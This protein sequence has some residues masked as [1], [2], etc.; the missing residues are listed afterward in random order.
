VEAVHSLFERQVER[1]PEAIAI[2]I[3]DTQVTYR[4]LNRHANQLAHALLDRGVSRD[5]FVGICLD[6]SVEMVAALLGTL[7]A[8]AAYVPLDPEYPAERL[9]Y[10][11]EDSGVRALF[12]TR[13]E[14]ACLEIDAS[15]DRLLVLD[16]LEAFGD[17]PE[18]DPGLPVDP[19]QLIYMIYTSG[20]TGKPK[21]SL[22]RHRGFANL[23]RWYAEEFGFDAET[24]VLHMTSP[25]FDLTQKNVFAPLAAGSRLCLLDQRF[26]DASVIVDHIE[27]H[28]CTLVNCTPSAFARLFAF[29]GDD[30]YRRI[31][32]LHFVVLGGEPIPMARLKDWLASDAC[33]AQI[34]NSYGPTE[35]TDVVSFY[36]VERPQRFLDGN[37]P[38][39][40]AL[41]GFRL[42]V[43]DDALRPVRT[44]ESGQLCIA[45]VGVGAG[46][47]GRPELTADRFREN[48]L[49]DGTGTRL[50]L[51]GDRARQLEDGNL[52]YLGR[53]DNQVKVRGFRI[54][55]GEVERALEAHEAIKEAAAAVFP[56]PAGDNR[57]AAY[58]VWE[59]EASA[60]AINEVRRFLQRS[61][62]DFMLP[63]AWVAL[64]RL[65]LTPNGKLDR[66]ALPEPTAE[67]P[68]LD[69]EFVEPRNAVEAYLA[70]LWLEVIGIDRIGIDDRF[71]ELG[72][73]SLN[74]VDFVARLSSELGERIPIASFFE[75]PT[76]RAFATELWMEHR[77]AMT[78]RFPD[79]AESARDEAPERGALVLRERGPADG[80]LA[81]VGM[82]GR[83]PG[84]DD[85][86]QL[87]ENLLDGV[88]SVRFASEEDLREAGVVEDD[89]SD[90]EYVRAYFSC[91]DVE[92][93]D[94]GFF[95]YTPREAELMDP[96]HRFFL[97]VAWSCLDNAGYGEPTAY[98]GR[99][100]VFGGA[101][102]DAYLHH[103][104]SLHPRYRDSLGDFSVN[105]GNDKNFPST[106]VAYKL[107][108]RGP[109]IN[110]QTAC[111]SSGVALHLACQSLRAGECDMALVGG[112]RVLVPTRSGYRHVENGP[113]S[114][115]GH[116]RTFDER[117][118]GMVR[119]SGAAFLLVKRLEDALNDQDC[120][121]GIVKAT[122]VNN[123]GSAKVGFTAPGVEGQAEVIA[124]AVVRAGVPVESIGYVEA[125]GTATAL[126]DPIEVRALTRAY[127]HFTDARQFC[128]IGSVKTNLGHLDAGAA[129][130]GIIKT[131][132]ALETGELPP[133]LH[134]ASPNPEI[135]FANSPFR[136]TERRRHW[137]A[138]Q[139]PRRAGVSSFGL[140]GTNFHGVFEEFRGPTGGSSHEGHRRWQLV[141]LSAKTPRSLSANLGGLARY[142]EVHPEVEVSDL[143]YSLNTFRP[144]FGERA[145]LLCEAGEEIGRTQLAAARRRGPVPQRSLVFFFPDANPDAVASREL[146]HDEAPFRRAI[147][148]CSEA[149]EPLLGFALAKHFFDADAPSDAASPRVQDA[150][151]FATQLGV[152][153]CLVSWGL[154]PSSLIGAGVG[155]IVAACQS[156]AL[157][158]ADAAALV[159]GLRA[160]AEGDTEAFGAAV[161]DLA[162]EEPTIDVQSVATGTVQS[163]ERL[164]DS[165]YWD[166]LRRARA[167]GPE[168][169]W[170]ELPRHRPASCVALGPLADDHPIHDLADD[171]FELVAAA[172]SSAGETLVRAVGELWL[173]GHEVEWLAYY[174]GHGVQK[175]PLPPFRFD[176]QRYW[177]DLPRRSTRLVT[178][179]VASEAEAHESLA[180]WADFAA[181]EK[182]VRW[183]E[184]VQ[185]RPP[186]PDGWRMAELA[187]RTEDLPTLLRDRGSGAFRARGA[188]A[189]AVTFLFPGGGAQYV[190]M[191]R[192]LYERHPV[193]RDVVDEGLALHHARTGEDLARVWLPRPDL[194]AWA[195]QELV[196]PSVQL[197]AIFIVEMAL[198]RLWMHWGV[199]P[200]ALI[201][202]SMGE[203]TAACLAGVM[204][205]PDALG[206]VA[207]RG[208]LFEQVEPGGMLSV[209][210]S[211]ED[212]ATYLGDEFDLATING[213]E[214]CTVSG[215]ADAL[216]VLKERFDA[217]GIDA[218]VVPI[219]IAAH[220]RLLD[221]ILERFGDY[222]RSI[223]LSAPE[224]PFV[225]NL[226]GT[227]VDASDACDPDYWV[228][229]LRSPVRF[230][231]GVQTLLEKPD[232]VFLECGPGRILGSLV[233]H[234]SSLDAEAV[235]SSLRHPDEES[236][237]LTFLLRTVGRLW[238]AGADL[239]WPRID[240]DLPGAC[241]HLPTRPPAGAV[242]SDAVVAPTLPAQADTQLAV[243][244]LQS[245]PIPTDA[246]PR[247]PSQESP[248]L[249]TRREL[250]RDTLTT[251]LHDMS[252]LN[253]S[254]LDPQSTFVNLGF[255]SLFLTQF[256]LRI[257]KR[258]KV[259]V[260]LRLL[261][262]DAPCL[263]ALAC[264]LDEQL[265]P[266]ALQE[267]LA[268][269]APAV[270]APAAPTQTLPA[271][272]VPASAAA[273][274][275]IAGGDALQQAIA[276]QIQASNALLALL[277]RSGAPQAV[278]S[279]PVQAPIAAPAIAPEAT[280]TVS[281][282]ETRD[283][284]SGR[285]QPEPS[286]AMG[287]Y[288][289]I[290]KSV[291][292]E[293]TEQQQ[294]YLAE[295]ID[296]YQKRTRKSQEFA[297]AHRR[298]YADPR[299]VMGFK[300]FWKDLTY[301]LVA[302]R[303]KGSRVRDIDGNEYVDCMSGFGAILFGH[304]PDFVLD[305]VRDQLDRT[306]DYG[307]QS[308]L[309]G[310]AAELLCEMTGMER[311]SFCNT[312]S[313]AV[314]AAV[315]VARTVTGND[316]VVTFSG[317]YHG[318]FDEFLV[319]SQTVGSQRRNLPLAPGIPESASQNV[320]VLDYGDPRSI[321]IV[322]ERAEEIAAVL[323][324]PIQ[325]RRP[326]L[327]PK[328]F[329]QELREVTR[330]ADVPMIFDE[331][332][333][334]FRLHPRGAQAWFDVDVDIACYGK[335]IGGGFPV[336]V[337]AGKAKYLDALDGGAW[338]F[339]DDSFPEVGVTYFA[340]TFIRHPVSIAAVHAALTHLKEQGPE[341]QARLNR[342]TAIFAERLN[343]ELRK[344]SIPLELS[345]AGSLFFPRWLGNPEHQG[346][347]DHHL[348]H[349]GAHHVWGGRPGFLTTAHTDE[350]IEL[351][352][353]AFVAA[354]EAMQR[355]G[356]LPLPSEIGS[357]RQAFTAVQS[358]LALAIQLGDEAA[359]AYN[360]QV[361]FELDHAI[362]AEAFELALDKAAHRH[363]SLRATV[364]EDGSG[365]VVHPDVAAQF[366]YED[367]S[368]LDSE[369]RE[370][371]VRKRAQHNIDEAFDARNGPLIRALV[372]KTGDAQSMICVC[373]NHLVCDGWSLER[374]MEDLAAYYSGIRQGRTVKRPTVPS[375]AEAFAA[376]QAQ[377]EDLPEAREF[378]LS[379]Y[380]EGVPPELDL[381]LDHP[382][383]RVRSYRGE[384]TSGYLD[385]ELCEPMR[386]HAKEA[387]CTSF[388]MMLSVFELLLHR[389]TGQE[390]LVVGIP[391]AGQPAIG[392]PELVSH[393][394]AFLPLRGRIETS[395]S[396]RDFMLR[397]Q[398]G[399]LDAKDHQSFA[400]GEILKELALPRD[401]S[402]LPLVTAS[403]NLDAAY[404]PLWFDGS[405]A[406]F[407]PGPRGRSKYDLLF[408]LTDEG[409]RV[410]VEVDRNAD[411]LDGATIER[412]VRS[413]QTLLREVLRDPERPIDEYP[414]MTEGERDEVLRTWN[415]TP[416]D[417]PLESATLHGLVE[418]S[419]DRNP[420][421]TAVVAE[422]GELTF[423][424][425][426]QRAN[427]LASVLRERGIGRDDRVA[428]MMERS[429]EMVV[430]LYGILKAGAAYL[431]ID[432]EHP[433]DR[434]AFILRESDAKLVLTQEPLRDRLPESG[435]F[436]ALD[437]GWSAISGGDD[438]RPADPARP[439]DLA[440]VI[441]T[442]GSTGAPKG[443]M[444]EHRGICNR[445][446]WMQEALPLGS[447]DRVLQKTPYTF[448][449]SVWEF[450]LP[451]LAGAT[452]VM[453]RP[454][455]HKESRYLADVIRREEI[456]YL[457]FVPSMLHLFLADPDAS[458][459]SS[460]RRV[461]CS[462]EALGRDLQNR[463]FD[464]LPEAELHNLYGPTEAAVDVSAWQC[465][466]EDPGET[467]P[468]GRPIAN[469]RL[470]V[471]DHRL[472]PVP[473]G[474]PGELYIGGVQVARGYLGRPDLTAERFVP[475]PFDDDP[476][477]RL[478]RTGDLARHRTDGALEYLGRNDFQVKV[479]G[480]RI[481]LGEIEE[482]LTSHPDVE[483]TVV[484][485][486]EDRTRDQRLVAYLVTQS[487]EQVATV[488]LR[489]IL[490]R[491]LPD[492]MIPQ[493]FVFL[494]ALPLTSSGKVD[495]AALPAPSTEPLAET[496]ELPADSIE[497]R[498]VEIW[499][500]ILGVEKMG[501]TADFFEVG[502]HSLLGTQ[503][504]AKLNEEFGADLSLVRL[505][506]C[507][508]I[509]EL[510]ALVRH[511][512]A[513]APA[514]AT[515]VTP[516]PTGEPAIA[517]SQQQRLW[518][519]EQIEPE[520]FAY[521]LPASFRL[522]GK[523]DV[524]AMQRAFDTIEQRHEVLRSGFRVDEGRLLQITHAS[525]GLDLTPVPS[526]EFG[527]DDLDGLVGVLR[528]RTGEPF[529]TENGPLF[530]AQLIE[531]GPDD[532]L[533]FFLIH[534]LVFDGWS[535]DILLNEL[536]LLYNA[537]RQDQESPLAKLPVQYADFATWQREWLKG[538]EVRNGLHYWLEQLAG[539][540]PVLELPIDKPRPS[541]QPHRARGVQFSL[542]EDL[543]ERLEA[544]A[545]RHGCTLFMAV[546]AL[547]GVLLHRYTR[548]TDLLVGSP[549]SGRNQ[550][551]VEQLLGS[552]INRLVL[553]LRVDPE[554]S[555]GDWL[556][557]VKRMSL[558]A[559]GH[560]ATPFEE[561]VKSLNPPRDP[562]RAPIVQTMFMYQD[563]RNRTDDLDGLERTQVNIDRVGAQS[564]LDLWVKREAHGMTGGFEYPTELFEH[565][566]IEGFA[567][568]LVELARRVTADASV[569]I[570]ALAS[571][572][573]RDLEQIA[574][575]NTT[576]EPRDESATFLNAFARRVHER[577]EH[578]AVCHAGDTLT[579]A[580]LDARSDRLAGEL[581]RAG[582]E[583]GARVGVQLERG[584]NLPAALIA[585]WKAGASYV[586]IDP[587]H[588]LA[589][590]R[591]MLESAGVAAVLTEARLVGDLEGLGCCP[592]EL[593]QAATD[594]DPRS[595]RSGI[596]PSPDDVAYTI[597]T[598][599]STGEPKAVEVPHRA[600]WN[601]LAAMSSEIGMGESDR[602]L[603][604][605][606]LAFDIA[607]LE[608]FLPLMAG[609]TVVIAPREAAEDGV[610]LGALIRAHAITVLQ[611]TPSTWRLL[612]RSG[613]EGTPGLTALS[614]GETL[615]PDLAA[616]LLER[617]DRLW[618]LYGPTET[619]VWSTACRITKVDAGVAIG[620]PIANTRCYVVDEALRPV[621][622]G[623]AGE[624]VIAGEGLAAGYLNAPD[625]TR[626]RYPDA[627]PPIG[628]RVYRTGDVVRWRADGSLEFYKR[629]DD[630]V[631]VRGFRIELGE[632][633]A[634]LRREPSIEDCAVSA[635]DYGVADHR[636]VAH[637]LFRP[638]E[639]MTSSELRVALREVLPAYMVPQHFEEIEGIPRTPNGK[640]DRVAL[641]AQ[642]P[643]WRDADQ[644]IPPRSDTEREIAR[645]WSDVLQS[646]S[647]SV[648]GRFFDMGGHSLLALEVI[649]RM[650]QA[651]GVR[652]HPQQ[653][654]MNT[655]EQL[656]ARIDQIGSDGGGPA[657]SDPEPCSD[658][659]GDATEPTSRSLIGRIT[660]KLLH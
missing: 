489:E 645:I 242:Q 317:D 293:L 72:G 494:D 200:D 331:I 452:L 144:D 328:E 43:L 655:L 114:R 461:I 230:A 70:S 318:V 220:S 228:R 593:H 33:H 53:L 513:S 554:A 314:L 189:S 601:L 51:T 562:S 277:A 617:V 125:H 173:A 438:R 76:I 379:I 421:H 395:L 112:A 550:V 47:R 506:E 468:I 57:L 391:A 201:G 49:D 622:V 209:G 620:R 659:R 465:D 514:S 394:V 38:I 190:Q 308:Q 430:A 637:I 640:I 479:R 602:L 641:E 64:E 196:R 598:S 631:K 495:R 34:V 63:T 401:P 474:V 516:R 29:A 572:S 353:E 440:Y 561:L 275:T 647:I 463:F 261:L 71:F 99:I 384:R 191:A 174:A 86:D 500:E 2:E 157:E 192:D 574:T 613:W 508:T 130:T 578:P 396:F 15:D 178:L 533:L 109:A 660:R 133:S 219:S 356:F 420:E 113:L 580:E 517:S 456:S 151:A 234:Q 105:L 21:G 386:R 558:E 649:H 218:Q 418:A 128:D 224:I 203:N 296:S 526:S 291:D 59:P 385:D 161:A 570:G 32:T 65:P 521:N 210:L 600:A 646:E 156:G 199:Q 150:L 142:T 324:E 188:S 524:D 233:K 204:S 546:L 253:P 145:F 644:A 556:G 141:T 390:D 345:Y 409:D 227:W 352:I 52:E 306:V 311:A 132:L 336:G 565:A 273:P 519:L 48:P 115:D 84:A 502:G 381:P 548:Q 162:P 326:E 160:E 467:V 354:G 294:Q 179:S 69:V 118:S 208:R 140:G 279:P 583:P 82:A 594:A 104:V 334:G 303:S 297:S 540:L 632:V 27:R 442:S 25:A 73:S 616:Q 643:G 350:D 425:L 363:P 377:A 399:F 614:G 397:V 436:L 415:D 335:V 624:L 206:L 610:Q 653:M 374:V 36:R 604:V 96:Q 195:S 530:K 404:N 553:R 560:Q 595:R 529:D 95:G 40:V 413:Y 539:E 470:Y 569:G 180:A 380:G 407:V 349:F 376:D 45:G 443:V 507:P 473:P 111:S 388:V 567:E 172:G 633:E 405:R 485:A 231:D 98:P 371:S 6:R 447:H 237:D 472:Q 437:S 37:V 493:H 439:G 267:E 171:E 295:F 333:T 321:E 527:V 18:D 378:W 221:P 476:A 251:M 434:I 515:R 555:F 542:D 471:L 383:P 446:L 412:W 122:A 402:R 648:D 501:V 90:P 31:E 264:H 330:Q 55:L 313:E 312:G 536:C 232:R 389:L 636:L 205:F 30:L 522:R 143:A 42:H 429:T 26:Y 596:E 250:I 310:P 367:F 325:S 531:L 638:G 39:G 184:L 185:S 5:D 346:L 423:A 240:A 626:A 249:L 566:S 268:A 372:M 226:T 298:H 591:Q 563:T 300:T 625:L 146:Y 448:D 110:V 453:A 289:A 618:N 119:G 286:T 323:I 258:F 357:E 432:P 307:P 134:Y 301:T 344:R 460:L 274:L 416:R 305:A 403:F 239:D 509:R 170:P 538:E 369:Q 375:L 288:R 481:E 183:S 272:P 187:S 28:R 464:A 278:A 366:A 584:L 120:I 528:E 534:N 603:A 368:S 41:P 285:E 7:K 319:R 433:A 3:G 214:Q 121:R 127:R 360:E 478:Y 292:G 547:Y 24:R 93:F 181:R 60:P 61:L 492:Y 271:Q 635:Q 581:T 1:T 559:F 365:F 658:P 351:L 101:A 244:S 504:L 597:F 62:P 255:D 91:D 606:T 496:F 216:S 419:V 358:E 612:L 466:P 8:G 137:P 491:F 169:T 263:D 458:R 497:E 512:D 106:R 22:V 444:N 642:R 589:R 450:F 35:C 316:L 248:P 656:A 469:T 20:S 245:L 280:P 652:V 276:L 287:G 486:R 88:E 426:D 630:Q 74:A 149:F 459:C 477:A 259:K 107:D 281:V 615:A 484:L 284:A 564:D 577:S 257:K 400:Y 102:R 246:V 627:S 207:L 557:H 454:G 44:G 223:R 657:P 451:L 304:A 551:D 260:A 650:E 361:V 50:Y 135:D 503:M 347:F 424:E 212:V 213:P 573:E 611:G 154:E 370:R 586:P 532:H 411:I 202:H 332:I 254:E 579:Y 92:F 166:A 576:E 131:L 309:A 159:A 505:F 382:R 320:L 46:Y 523:L 89:I 252:G 549:I 535:F 499:C 619:T 256:N 138:E 283:P 23:A 177:V 414:L 482:R 235:L 343:R 225:S 165:L 599:G 408:T 282:P 338:Q 544:V 290:Q 315:R 387:G 525:L 487:G 67:R 393:T 490:K 537:F 9:H 123:D 341:L 68:D 337:I 167:A 362:D 398:N 152:A 520:S 445:L 17:L 16:D 116:L 108:L 85:V 79:V 238:R 243:P 455:G 552:F 592:I 139:T 215:R 78:R 435:A 193:F 480:L 628:E 543:V 359:S 14:A 58:L 510:S 545:T 605:T 654:W 87:W 66:R 302:E 322:R 198:A 4:E 163:A 175:V 241:M 608:T 269:T 217:D 80:D 168:T 13:A 590:R 428:V 94:A 97:E 148:A 609:A 462:G 568:S 518:Y 155:E 147:D 247:A 19:E 639:V 364:A 585:T 587:S 498:I 266:E 340:G 262:K 575:W 186:Q 75:S 588:P 117:G 153:R 211:A 475:D 176:R 449:V 158:L 83:F 54:E 422:N 182:D 623:A 339:G 621:P 327:Q 441:Y 582:V 103:Y 164:S 373:A 392:M 342:R 129:A 355:G 406:R 427:Q 10:M 126:G 12:T 124:Q 541:Y 229:H 299:T 270:A 194:E 222:L 236:S 511:R 651:L 56:D 81:V 410:L 100:G 629:L 431:P 457:H 483:R 265:P 11:L 136:V 571:A 197:P 329:L 634:A 77:G 417:Y 488:E 348:R 607:F